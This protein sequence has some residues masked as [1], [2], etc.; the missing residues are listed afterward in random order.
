MISPHMGFGPLLQFLLD[1][2]G[3]LLL[4]HKIHQYLGQPYKLNIPQYMRGSKIA[5][6]VLLLGILGLQ[7]VPEHKIHQFPCQHCTPYTPQSLQS[8]MPFHHL[9]N[10][11]N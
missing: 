1:I 7:F 11:E 6:L 3:C 5:V 4:W 2:L 8:S 10:L 9:Q